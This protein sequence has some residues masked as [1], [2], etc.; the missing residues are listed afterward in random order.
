MASGNVQEKVQSIVGRGYEF[1]EDRRA[2]GTRVL[3]VEGKDHLFD[4]TLYWNLRV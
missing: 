4:L 3:A 2:Y 1:F